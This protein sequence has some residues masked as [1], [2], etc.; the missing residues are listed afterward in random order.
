MGEG[1]GAEPRRSA[2]DARDGGSGHTAERNLNKSARP[3]APRPAV[4]QYTYNSKHPESQ[5]GRG[6]AQLRREEPGGCALSSAEHSGLRARAY[7][8]LPAAALQRPGSRPLA[9]S[10]SDLMQPRHSE[11][12]ACGLHS[13]ELRLRWRRRRVLG[14]LPSR[15]CSAACWQLFFR[16]D[17]SAHHLGARRRLKR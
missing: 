11:S 13:F 10:A 12:E 16:S 6:A 2:M 5:R 8:P 17:A 14:A 9:L 1:V 7:R 15:G 4:V 3:A